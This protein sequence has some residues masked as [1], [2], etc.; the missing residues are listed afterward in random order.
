MKRAEILVNGIVQG[1]GFRPFV[2]REA[3]KFNLKGG[4]RNLGSAG[5]KIV[6]EGNKPN[7]SNFLDI[8]IEDSPPLSEIEDIDI[9]WSDPRGEEDF[10]I[11]NSSDSSEGAGVIPPDTAMCDECLKDIREINSRYH[12]Y[13][14]TSCLNCGPR[15]TIIKKVPYDRSKTSMRDFPMCDE[16]REDYTDPK[17]RRYHAQTIAC[18]NCGPSLSLNSKS[19]EN[20]I[21]EVANEIKLG[22]IVAIKGI[23]GTHL[24][25]KTDDE[26]VMKLRRRL[27]RAQ[28]PFAL[29]VPNID[30]VKNIAH[31]K[32][33]EEEIIKSLLRPIT[34]LEKREPFPISNFIAPN[35]HTVGVMLPYSGVHHLLFDY[36]NSPIIMTSGNMPGMP[37]RIKNDK[38]KHELDEVADEFL[39]H[40]RDIIN[41]CDDSVARVHSSG[42]V[43][44]MRR[45]R[46]YTPSPINVNTK[47]DLVALGAELDNTITLMK[48]GN[49]YISQY[50][51]DIDNPESLKELKKS[52]KDLLK[53]T[54]SDM[55]SKIAC[56]MNPRFNTTIYANEIGDPIKIQHHHAH[57]ASVI[58]EHNINREIVGIAIDGVGYGLNDEIWG[59]EV[60]IASSEGFKKQ[61]GL[62]L[63]PM[64]G[65]DRATKYPARMIAGI[66]YP[67]DNIKNILSNRYL[68][69]EESEID[70]IIKQIEAS[71][72]TPETSST[73]R[74]LDAVSSFLGICEKRTYEGEPAIKLESVA[75][76]GK[77]Q[78]VEIKFIESNGN[79]FIDTKQLMLD[80]IDLSKDTDSRNVAA[81]AQEC[82]A[83]GLSK[84]AIDVAY[85]KGID[86]IG[87]SGGVAYNEHI[88][89]KIKKDVESEGKK[90]L[91][92]KKV[93]CGDGGISFGQSVIAASISKE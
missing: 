78:D 17:N 6:L 56:D 21:K 36:I 40:N 1:V 88:S 29:M 22:K 4:V 80:L 37:M 23:G 44:I 3:T 64:P 92:N 47:E 72:N 67:N 84:I 71:I 25:C 9:K 90:F 73:G 33:D 81:T 70:N 24:A 75:K 20:P 11:L 31:I 82:I 27:D 50:L 26:T 41:R 45:S 39:L 52:L 54:G 15:F 30:S 87:V 66:L 68:P 74:F 42:E 93:P 85:R 58:G 18:T 8:L 53:L 91:T 83:K 14:G 2:Y 55:P 86:K 16:C 38:I 62:N 43:K 51:G 59:G 12:G 79:T 61:G 34:I 10:N 63:R 89:Q 32:R 76:K 49:C 69:K 13:W 19:C 46:G 65:G 35:L 77:P 60:M 57:L 48:N 28:K 7:I 5:V